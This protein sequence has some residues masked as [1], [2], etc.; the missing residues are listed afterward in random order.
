MSEE[1]TVEGYRVVIEK[2][3]GTHVVSVP[4]L[5]GCTV[6]VDKREDIAKEITRVIGSYLGE[7]IQ[8]RPKMKKKPD[9]EGERKPGAEKERRKV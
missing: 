2:T 8:S 9:P 1:I 7:L 3:G 5:P 4:A 6:Q